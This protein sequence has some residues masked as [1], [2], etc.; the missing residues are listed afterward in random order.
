MPSDDETWAGGGFGCS[1]GG[2][3][4]GVGKA[5]ASSGIQAH[6]SGGRS[7]MAGKSRLEPTK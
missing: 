6:S 7:F 5:Q 3:S 2:G 4:G 1:N